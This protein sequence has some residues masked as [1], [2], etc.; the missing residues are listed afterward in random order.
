L[1]FTADGW[2]IYANGN[3][4][5]LPIQLRAIAMSLSLSVVYVVRENTE[6]EYSSVVGRIFEGTERETVE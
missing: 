2:K 6:G 4:P 3:L 5:I 1:L